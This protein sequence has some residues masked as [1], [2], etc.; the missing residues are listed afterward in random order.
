LVRAGMMRQVARG[1]YDLLPLGLRAVRRFEAIVREEMDRAGAQEILM[2]AVIPAELWQESGRWEQYG[3]ELLRFKDR[4]DRDCCFGPTHEEVVT[5]LVRREV[6]SYRDLPKN[7]YQIQVK[8]RDEVRP[9]FGLMRGREFLMKDAYSFHA[10]AE[11]V[12]HKLLVRAGMIRQ[13][14]RG[15]YDFLPLGLRAVRRVEAIVREEMNRSGA[16]EVLMPAVCPAELWRESGRWEQYGRELL[17]FKDRHEREFCFGPT[18]EEVVTDI[19]RREI[20]SYRQLPLNLYQIQV[21]FRDEVRPRFGL[22]RGREF[23][24]K[25]AYSFHTSFEDCR[26]EYDNMFR[27][28]ER[29]FTRCGLRFR[30]VEA[31]TGTIGGSLSHEF[32]VLADSGEDAIASCTRCGYAANVEKAEGRVTEAAAPGPGRALEKVPTPGKRSVEEVSAF[33]GL[34]PERFVKTLVYVTDSGEAVAALVR[35]DRDLSEAKLKNAA[36]AIAV[37]MADEDTVRRVTGAPVGYAGPVGLDC[38]VF[39]D[40]GLRGMRGAVSGANEVDAHYVGVDLD[41]DAPHLRYVDLRIVRGGDACARC[42]EGRF[43]IHRGIEVGQVFYLGTKYSQ[44][45]RATVLD[46]AGAEQVIEM[47]CYGI[48]ITRTVAAA[49]EQNHDANGI[50]WPIPLAPFPAS[51]VPVN[52]DSAE[53]WDVAQRIY[54]ELREQGIEALIDDREERPGVKFKDADLIGIPLRVTVGAKALARGNVELKERR[55]EKAVEVPVG[56]AAGRVAA[57]VRRQSAP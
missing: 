43:E 18:H 56:E 49:I 54:R 25:D 11:V 42:S 22:M 36:G 15:I 2:P 31:D 30:P 57:E 3:R 46:A 20:R 34:E 29:I 23:L 13:V 5:D 32:Q 39:A 26:R 52:R 44:A 55:A 35:G 38:R 10:D 7:L 8:F 17:R 51:V 27:T 9:R 53:L 40:Q 12:S 21:K 6:R 1:I 37:A 14:A 24:M 48:G 47:G 33:L 19:V 4:Y 28:Y 16:Q 41:R 50:I 45:L